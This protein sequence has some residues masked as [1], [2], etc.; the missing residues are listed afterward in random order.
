MYTLTT[1]NKCQCQDLILA[2]V[3]V[4]NIHIV[5][6]LNSLGAYAACTVHEQNSM[7]ARHERT[8]YT[9]AVACVLY[10]A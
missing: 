4:L 3:S 10:S 7:V 5:H 8:N 2:A 9:H 1:S 6:D